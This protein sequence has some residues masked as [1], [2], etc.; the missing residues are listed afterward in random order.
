[1]KEDDDAERE[2]VD[3]RGD[4]GDAAHADLRARGRGYGNLRGLAGG[5]NFG[6]RYVRGCSCDGCH[7]GEVPGEWRRAH[8]S[9]DIVSEGTPETCPI[10]HSEQRTAYS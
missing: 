7:R 2:P 10:V 4:A 3:A 9:T 6:S 8:P 5:G 1:V